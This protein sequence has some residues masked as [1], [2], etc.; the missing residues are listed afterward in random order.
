MIISLLEL[1]P[2]Q[3]KENTILEIL[4]YVKEKVRLKRGCIECKVYRSY[5]DDQTILYLEFWQAEE[6]LHG[7]VQS[8][9]YLHLLNA[10]DF[11]RE[12]PE[13]FFYE[14]TTSNSMDLIKTLRLK[15]DL[16][17]RTKEN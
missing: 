6:E 14:V 2:L 4:Q 17:G 11:C 13:I 10:M 12:K 3:E 8:P 9:Q 7:H 5:N 15:D 16:P 1:K